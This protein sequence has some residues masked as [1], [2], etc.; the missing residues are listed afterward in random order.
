VRAG[1]GNDELAGATGNDT[2][3]GGPGSDVLSGGAGRNTYA[4]GPGNDRIHAA[5]GIR[6]VVD[7]GAGHDA[8]RAD[9]SDTLDART[10]LTNPPLKS[11][12]TASGPSRWRRE[13]DAG[14]V[15]AL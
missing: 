2:L 13:P 10:C 6:D 1:D 3:D 14:S 15:R 9:R 7:C 11:Y 8:V 12:E 4:A 5:N